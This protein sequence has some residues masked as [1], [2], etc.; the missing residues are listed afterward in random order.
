M[1]TK[2]EISSLTEDDLSFLGL[3]CFAYACGSMST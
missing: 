2:F 3:L 1:E